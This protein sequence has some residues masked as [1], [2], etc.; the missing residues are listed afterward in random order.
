VYYQP[1]IDLRT[2]R[3]GGAEAL[4]R[5]QHPQRGLL[6]PGEFM[7]LAEGSDLAA[8][9]DCW[10]LQTAC[11]HNL[12][13]EESDSGALRVAV[14]LSAR[15]LRGGRLPA[16][17]AETLARTGLPPSRLVLE[18]AERQAL[19]DAAGTVATLAELQRL[20]V[21]VVIDDFGSGLASLTALRRLPIN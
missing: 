17:V 9:I 4:V 2:G 16:A 21:R 19:G 1:Q 11:A 13:W 20:G 18:V 6:R 8:A 10:V 3:M 14:N 7:P 12:S 5:W 15:H